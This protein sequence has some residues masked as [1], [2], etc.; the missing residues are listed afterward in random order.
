MVYIEFFIFF[1]DAMSGAD[2]I[3]SAEFEIVAKRNP[4]L[5]RMFTIPCLDRMHA[6]V[7]KH[8]PLTKTVTEKR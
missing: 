5:I 7:A 6:T 2:G 3:S 1:Q 4:R 8:F